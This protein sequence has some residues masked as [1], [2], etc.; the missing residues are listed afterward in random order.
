MKIFSIILVL[1]P[2]IFEGQGKDADE[3]SVR[4]D[5]SA[6]FINI[7]VESNINRLFFKYDLNALNV[8]NV[9][10]TGTEREKDTSA[11]LVKVPVREFKS[12]SKL[13]YRDF[14]ALLKAKQYP[15]LEVTVPKLTG[16]IHQTNGSFLLKGLRIKVAGV[17]KEYDIYCKIEQ[18]ENNNKIFIGSTRIKLTDID[19]DPPVKFSG[20]LKVKDEII[21]KFG[22]CLR[23]SNDI[24]TLF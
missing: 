7:T 5:C 23:S 4:D 18:T 24:I 10:F 9:S 20:L 2:L 22:F 19:I 12:S 17:A 16:I 15:F 14:L 1:F 13:V 8:H 3:R 6:G 11:S 21:V